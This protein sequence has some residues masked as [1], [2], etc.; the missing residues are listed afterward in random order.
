MEFKKFSPF[1]VSLHDLCSSSRL[2][3]PKDAGFLSFVKR[4]S[5]IFFPQWALLANSFLLLHQRF[6]LPFPNANI[7]VHAFCKSHHGNLFTLQTIWPVLV[8]RMQI[9]DGK[10]STTSQRSHFFNIFFPECLHAELNTLQAF[11]VSRGLAV[12]VTSVTAH[13]EI[14]GFPWISKKTK[15]AGF[16]LSMELNPD[17]IDN[18]RHPWGVVL[19]TQMP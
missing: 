10:H 8:T 4:P 14:Q 12:A 16:V 2:V 6:W 13:P 15:Q 1:G 7:L 3:L 19:A 5:E 11:L 18:N 9:A 17:P